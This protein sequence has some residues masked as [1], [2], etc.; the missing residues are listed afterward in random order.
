MRTCHSTMILDVK[1]VFLVSI[2]YWY[3]QQIQLVFG[4]RVPGRR[5]AR[6]VY[7]LSSKF[8]FGTFVVY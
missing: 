5:C 2:T 1:L 4:L 3:S 6:C 7:P 8:R